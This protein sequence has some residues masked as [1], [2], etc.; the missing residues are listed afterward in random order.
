MFPGYLK[1]VN[2]AAIFNI[3]QTAIVDSTQIADFPCHNVG[4]GM[5]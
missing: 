5:S 2:E 1:I 3:K 4:D